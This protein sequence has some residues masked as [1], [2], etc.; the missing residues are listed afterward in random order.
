LRGATQAP[1]FRQAV[2]EEK[3]LENAQARRTRC[4]AKDCAQRLR[5]P[6]DDYI[7]RRHLVGNLR[8]AAGQ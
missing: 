3:L 5:S 1:R 4:S 7:E 2:H 6:A 8:A